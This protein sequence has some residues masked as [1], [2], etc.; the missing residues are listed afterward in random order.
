MVGVDG[1]AGSLRALRWALE[2]ATLRRAALQ[3]VMVWRGVEADD[4]TAFEFA[5]FRS[6]A[7]YD[8]GA[9]TLAGEHLR[10][11]LSEALG[12]AAGRVE[13]I[14]LE[15]HP[16][17][18]LCEHATGADLLVVGSRGHGALAEVLLGSV[19][20]ACARRS[21]CPLAVVPSRRGRRAATPASEPR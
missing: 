4:E 18:A 14:V 8:R 19:S 11:L 15:G 17:D 2:E 10:D 6:L 13:P 1:S 12:E 21:P 16:V 3:A 7:G 5:T 20:A 9:A